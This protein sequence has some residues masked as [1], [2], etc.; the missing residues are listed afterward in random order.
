MNKIKILLLLTLLIIIN[1][2][3]VAKEK[4]FIIYNVNN[5]LITNIDLKKESKYL[6]ALNSQLKTLNEEKILSIAKESILRETIKKI[7]LRKYFDL[8]TINPLVDS[9]IKNFYSKLNLNNEIEFQEFLQSNELP[10]NFVKKKINIE[11]TWNQ[12]IFDKFNNELK[13][14]K[15]EI[16]KKIRSSKDNTEEKIYLLSEIVFEVDTQNNLNK[17]KDNIK[18]SINEI[19]FKNSANIYSISDSSKFG[20]QLG[21]ITEKELSHKVFKNINKIKIGEYTT[22]INMGTSFLILKVDNIKY[23]KKK[24]NIKQEINIKIKTETNRQLK[25]YSEIYYNQ[26]KINTNIDE[27]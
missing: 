6:I 16:A 17:K 10:L 20:G 7:E 12:L 9:Y 27:L 5:E 1:T 26:I 8:K 24:R 13:I 22:P 19:G 15:E 11:I 2:N 25:K 4:I 21:W 18:K 3:T 23:E 14:N